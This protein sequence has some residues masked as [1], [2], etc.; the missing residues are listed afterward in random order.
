[1]Y[2]SIILEKRELCNNRGTGFL[3]FSTSW[4]LSL[5]F[6]GHACVCITYILDVTILKF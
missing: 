4:K 2:I 1:M 6:I 5:Q 3:Q